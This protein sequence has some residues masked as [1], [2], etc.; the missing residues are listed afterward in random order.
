M[1]VDMTVAMSKTERLLTERN[2]DRRVKIA[3]KLKVALDLMVWG[4]ADGTPLDYDDAARNANLTVR[5]MRKALEK[6]HVRMYLR[7]QREVFRAAISTRTISRL[8]ELRDQNDNRN[9]AVAAARALEQI[10]EEAEA[11]PPQQQTPG[12]VIVVTNAPTH[13]QAVASPVTIEAT[14]ERDPEPIE[15]RKGQGSG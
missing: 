6:P 2:R 7:Q 1:F 15:E 4:D 3:G 12:F 13:L 8:A 11:R 10:G 5:A 14:P 9:A